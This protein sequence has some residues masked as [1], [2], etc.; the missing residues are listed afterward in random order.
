MTTTTREGYVEDLVR[1]VAPALRAS[2]A[3]SE[4]ARQLAPE[5]MDV[6]LNAGILRALL[7][8][9]YGGAELGAVGGHKL[10][11]EL[12]SID[13]AASWSAMIGAAGAWLTLLLPS[14]AAD[15]ILADPRAVVVGSFNPPLS[16]E[17]VPGGYR[18]SGQVSFA[19]GCTHATWLIAQ[20]LV[21]EEG[22]PKIG[23]GGMPVALAVFFPA[24]DATII[25]NWQTLGMRGTGSHDFRVSACFVPEHR[26]WPMGP[27]APVN[28]AFTDPLSRMALWWFSTSLAAVAL[29]IARAAIADL[30]DLA[31]SKTPSYTQV[32]L[33][34]KPVVQEKLARAR[35]AVDAA[36]SY[37]YDA[38]TG[39]EEILRTEPRLSIEQ[40]VPLA[41]AASHGVEAAVQAVDLVQN[42]AGT[43]GIRNERR[44]QQ[45]FRDVHTI[46]AH[47][48]ASTAR[49][50]SIG[51]LLLGRP[52]DWPFYYL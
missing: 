45:Y 12:A 30:S 1:S 4:A 47:A 21:M 26:I 10:L 33:A 11:E 50:E 14:P 9:A 20:A 28:S 29:G 36:R 41:L 16:A 46:S 31:Q 3:A 19:S 24:A 7:P 13:S 37:L 39:A 52:S 18:V 23:P 51:K 42:C 32:G 5:A 35:A 34:D 2:A 38:L 48:F 40:G 8:A 27:W 25:E 17:A 15:E 44:F 49:F 6:L 22:A 43:A